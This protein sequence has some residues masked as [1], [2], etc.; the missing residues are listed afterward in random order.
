MVRRIGDCGGGTEEAGDVV[1]LPPSP[2]VTM[3]YNVESVTLSGK[4]HKIACFDKI[5]FVY[6]LF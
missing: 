5:L 2:F 1:E 6:R 4:C 3:S